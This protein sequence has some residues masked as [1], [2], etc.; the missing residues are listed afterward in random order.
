MVIFSYILPTFAAIL[1]EVRG[2]GQFTREVGETHC[3]QE[4]KYDL[5]WTAGQRP[6]RRTCFEQ[7]P[8]DTSLLFFLYRS[9]LGHQVD[10]LD[11]SNGPK[12]AYILPRAL[13][14]IS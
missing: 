7:G 14:C 9:T 13:N 11:N 2:R 8:H 3:V 12:H 10:V 5:R 6:R 1:K 4:S